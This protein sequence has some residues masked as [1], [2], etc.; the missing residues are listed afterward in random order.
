MTDKG[1]IV[2]TGRR[3]C[4]RFNGEEKNYKGWKNQVLDWLLVVGENVQYPAIEIRLSLSG[5]ALEAAEELDRKELIKKGGEERIL[6]CLDKIFLRDS[7]MDRYGKLKEYFKIEREVGESMRAFIQ[8]YEKIESECKRALDSPMFSEE[9]KGFHVLEQANLAEGQRQMVIAAC[10]QDKLEYEVVSRIMR[11]M[12]DSMEE[13]KEDE[14]WGSE[15]RGEATNSRREAKNYTKRKNPIG[16]D[17]RVSKCAICKSEWHWAKD[18]S[19]NIRNKEKEGKDDSN[20]KE[21]YREK[22]F[23][24]EIGD[25]REES[26]KGVEA[27]VDT[28]C[29]STICGELWLE[30]IRMG[31]SREDKERIEK[32]REGSD[33]VFNFGETSLQSKGV[34]QLPAIVGGKKVY[35]RTE[36]VD[37]GLPWLIGLETMK[38][39]GMTLEM[40]SK[41]AM[42]EELGARIKLRE[43]NKG[44]LRLHI[45]S[46]QGEE[47][48]MEGWSDKDVSKV[49][50]KLHRQ[51]GHGSANKLWKLTEDAGWSKGM[52]EKEKQETR[53][54]M[55]EIIAECETCR[56]YRRNPAKPVVGFSWS[57]VFNEVVAVD[58]GEIE[59]RKFLVMVDMATRYCQARWVVDKTPERVLEGMMDGWIRIFGPPC[60]VLSDN[61]GEFQNEKMHEMAGKWNIKVM[62][63]PAESPWSN[64]LCERTVGLIKDQLRKLR[65][66]E[67]V[68]WKLALPWATLARNCL[69]NNGGFAPNQLVFGKKK[70][71]YPV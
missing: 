60:K 61:G 16:K 59:G 35:L 43:D 51:F 8:R 31:L 56:K 10:G 37:G 28:G 47:L 7:V 26:W 55:E 34:L 63:T 42:L 65:D 49:V 30:R 11:R 33:K 9:L 23:A 22:V 57:H 17:G 58:L 54:L 70:Q 27:I 40:R 21:K 38:K 1:K 36:I 12:F 2:M 45:R 69:M 68:S 15:R 52:G 67:G 53:R 64:G 18:C 19:Q 41:T 24:E 71:C 66:G 39:L 13:G 50:E 46:Y 48:F 20:G 25:I 29:R 32:T 3:E 6:E 4:P 14:W 5:K 62:T 44:H